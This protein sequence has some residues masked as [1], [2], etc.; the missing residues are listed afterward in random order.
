MKTPLRA[1]RG[2]CDRSLVS[3]H[4]G[5]AWSWSATAGLPYPWFFPE[6]K[7]EARDGNEDCR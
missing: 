3:D 5:V 7:E 1:W 4:F 2:V 6:A